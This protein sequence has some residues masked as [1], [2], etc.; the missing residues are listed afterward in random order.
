MGLHWNL[1]RFVQGLILYVLV[2]AVSVGILL[3]ASSGTRETLV[4]AMFFAVIPGVLILGFALL[5]QKWYGPGKKQQFLTWFWAI[6][7]SVIIAV[8]WFRIF[9]QTMTHTTTA[10]LA[11]L[12]LGIIPLFLIYWP[13]LWYGRRHGWGWRR[14]SWAMNG[15]AV[16]WGIIL[17]AW[18]WGL[19]F[20]WFVIIMAALGVACVTWA[21]VVPKNKALD[22]DHL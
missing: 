5:F 10:V 11:F 2:G 9:P 6:T 7:G 22:D 3:P 12:L 18:V 17:P 4:P 15:I 21:L 16:V 14:F 13:F 20:D 8:I 19:L 1:A